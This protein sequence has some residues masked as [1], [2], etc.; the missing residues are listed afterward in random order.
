MDRRPRRTPP[1]D[2]ASLRS[3]ALEL[4]RFDSLERP[5]SESE[6]QDCSIIVLPGAGHGRSVDK[7][8]RTAGTDLCAG[9]HRGSPHGY[10]AFGGCRCPQRRPRG[11][12][13]SCSPTTATRHV[14]LPTGCTG[15]SD[16]RTARSLATDRAALPLLAR[17]AAARPQS[18]WTMCAARSPHGGPLRQHGSRPAAKSLRWLT[19]FVDVRHSR[20]DA[21][22]R[23]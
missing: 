14:S 15:R 12:P 1:A 8:R 20:H 4:A 23:G 19:T 5:Q 22:P 3:Q 17:A 11:R 7:M 18:S 13:A 6:Q 16:L 10:H 2:P 9:T 21:T